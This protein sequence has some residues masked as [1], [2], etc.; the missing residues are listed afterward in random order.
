MSKV[1]FTNLF[2]INGGLAKGPLIVGRTSGAAA[3]APAGAGPAPATPAGITVTVI[4]V[5]AP[6][7][8]VKVN[9]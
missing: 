6:F 8:S 4:C 9:V 3:A 7:A 2:M 5:V 1:V